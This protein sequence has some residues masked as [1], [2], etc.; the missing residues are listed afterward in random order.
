MIARVAGCGGVGPVKYD[1]ERC[2]I[3]GHQATLT[4]V[5]AA[6]ASVSQRIVERQPWFAVVTLLVVVIAGASNIE[7]LLVVVRARKVGHDR[8]WNERLRDALE[9]QR[10]R[11]LRYFSIVGAM[12]ILLVLAV[13]FYI[14][15]DAD[16]RTSQHALA[17]LQFCQISLKSDDERQALDEQRKNLASIQSTAGDIRALVDKLPPEEQRKGQMIVDQ[18]NSALQRQG[19]MVGDYL[20]RSDEAAKELLAHTADV[21]KGLTTLQSDIAV[22]KVLPSLL[23]DVGDQLR[24][25]DARGGDNTG[26]L[27]A[28]QGQLGELDAEVKKLLARP[29]CEV[30][31]A[32]ATTGAARVGDLGVR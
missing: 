4:E 1:N 21:Q 8:P 29:V 7:K 2:F 22:L 32:A 11:P 14:Y 9:R 25:V 5:E 19:K 10:E 27:A 13:A 6:Q 31:K 17:T 15:L 24:K 30:P 20:T 28:M 3:D 23:R 18:M 12:M 26:R 16:K